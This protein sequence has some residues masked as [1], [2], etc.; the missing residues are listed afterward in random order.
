MDKEIK[1]AWVEGLQFG[2]YKQGVGYLRTLDDR[3]CVM[4][5]LA[6]VAGLRWSK[7]P[8]GYAVLGSTCGL[9]DQIIERF[10]ID[11]YTQAFLMRMSDCRIP[12][13]EIADWIDENL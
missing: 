7:T 1:K 11:P 6:S 5:V 10:G 12:F 2:E 9:H 13:P 4:G 8:N 3:Y